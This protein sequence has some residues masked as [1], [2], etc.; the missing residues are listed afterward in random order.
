MKKT[1]AIVALILAISVSLIAGTAS[2]YTTTLEE[3]TA[4]EVTAKEFILVEEG[5][6]SGSIP[7]EKIAPGEEVTFDFAVKNNEGELTTETDMEVSFTVELVKNGQLEEI[8]PLKISSVVCDRHLLPEL[9][10]KDGVYTDDVTF[11]A[12]VS[13]KKT[14]KVTVE[15]PWET[16][17]VKDIEFA[18][19]DYGAA[20]QVTVTGTQV[21]K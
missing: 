13:E 15:W 21:Q 9:V 11:K 14:Y 17:G 6:L 1:L 20:V 18:G 4:G 16:D 3:L 19:A 10:A 12:N 8:K 2:Y 7:L 5:S